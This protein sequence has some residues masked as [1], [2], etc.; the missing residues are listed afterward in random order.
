[1]F[2]S[3]HLFSTTV[4]GKREIERV[5]IDSFSR[6]SA[7]SSGSE[8]RGCYVLAEEEKE[9]DDDNKC[10]DVGMMET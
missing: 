5:C 6:C 9:E 10:E 8:G 3:S 4:N 7:L 2:S 1:M